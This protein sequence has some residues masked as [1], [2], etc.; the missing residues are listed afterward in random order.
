MFRQNSGPSWT[1]SCL[2]W[3]MGMAAP[4]TETLP[5]SSSKKIPRWLPPFWRLTRRLWPCLPT[6]WTCSM[7]QT[8]NPA[9]TCSTVRPGDC[10]AC[11]PPL[12]WTWF[13]WAR[14]CTGFCAMGMFSSRILNCPSEPCQKVHWRPGTNTTEEPGNTMPGRHLW[15]TM[16]R[17]FSITYCA[18][19]I[20]I[21]SWES[22][23][24]A[25]SL[26]LYQ[27]SSFF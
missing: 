21:C 18:Q 13:L 8:A 26:T 24:I 25:A 15:K 6:C 12:L 19:V 5:G 23:R 7:I 16:C 17:M 2:W 11:S 4:T 3:S 27:Y 20:P 14:V 22:C 10:S 9:V 1:S